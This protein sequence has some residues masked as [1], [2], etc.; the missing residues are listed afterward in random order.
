MRRSI[1]VVLAVS[2]IL[3]DQITKILIKSNLFE[4][5]SIV[6]IP[7]FLDFTYVP[8][9]GAAFGMLQGE[10]WIFLSVT[11]IIIVITLFLLLANKIKSNLTIFAATLIISGGIGNM[12]DRIFRG[13]V[14][15]FI[16]FKM[17]WAYVFNVAD[18]CVVIGSSLIIIK[19]FLDIYHDKKRNEVSGNTDSGSNE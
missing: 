1:A 3:I 19:L 2:L 14:I 9:G 15:D 11:A 18:S 5:Q 10:R 6:I 12:I 7:N 13:Y 4:S 16:N 8:N 17:I